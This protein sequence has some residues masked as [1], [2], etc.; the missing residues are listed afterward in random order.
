MTMP[1]NFHETCLN[2]TSTRAKTVK[3]T[4]QDQGPGCLSAETRVHLLVVSW[5]LFQKWG[6]DNQ[7][8]R[9]GSSRGAPEPALETTGRE[10]F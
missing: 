3:G 7:L 10:M 1:I 2:N 8:G 5:G 6:Q 9:E 4:E